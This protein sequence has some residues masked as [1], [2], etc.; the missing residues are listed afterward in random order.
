MDTRDLQEKR[1]ELM[2]EVLTAFNETFGLEADYYEEVEQGDIPEAEWAEFLSKWEDEISHINEING[3]EK[4]IGSEFGHGEYMIPSD[5]WEDYVQD[6]VQ[7]CG[8]IS[9][10]FPSWIYID[11]ERTAKD[12]AYD[13]MVVTY[14]GEDYYV[15]NC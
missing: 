11:W 4:E 10:D 1:D 3:L 12:V 7:D 8:Y 5:E 2:D 6:L 9:K 15:R 14:Q 13:Y